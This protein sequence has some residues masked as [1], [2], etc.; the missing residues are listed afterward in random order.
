MTR[1]TGLK[2][3]ILD[4]I[5][6]HTAL[7]VTA[8]FISLHTGDPS[9]TGANECTGGDYVRKS[10]SFEASG[11]GTAGECRND[12]AITWTVMPA[13]TVKWVG[14]WDAIAGNWLWGGQLTADKVVNAGD[15]FTFA[16][17]A[18]K[19]SDVDM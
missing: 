15:T 9:T 6:N 16:I 2:N 1:S 19:L 3:R 17:N 14:V 11:A 12:V 7:D 13:C 5:C 10:A 18:L 4:A 8:S